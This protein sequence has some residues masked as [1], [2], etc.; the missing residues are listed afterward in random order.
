MRQGILRLETEDMARN[1]FLPFGDL[2]KAFR[3]RR[4][5]TQQELAALAGVHRNTIGRW[6]RGDI[7]PESRT[8]V[9]DLARVLCLDALET[10]QLLA[11]SLTTQAL[12]WDIPYPRNPLFTGR[13]KLLTRLHERMQSDLAYGLPPSYALQGLGGIGKTQTALEYAYRYCQDATVVLWIRGET[14]E[15]I[16]RSFVDIAELL[17][18]PER[19]LANQQQI[20]LAVQDWLVQTHDWLA[21]WDNVEEVDLLRRFL[22]ARRQGSVLL[23]TRRHALGN[24]AQGIELPPLPPEEGVLFLLRRAKLLEPG[25]GRAQLQHL[26]ER[27]P[28]EYAAAEEL[29]ALLDGLPL[30]LDQVG[31]YV[32][33]TG[34]GL[35]TYLRYFEPYQHQLLGRRGTPQ[36]DHPASVMRTF[37]MAYEQVKQ[38]HPAAAELLCFCTLLAPDAI[39]EELIIKGAPHLGPILQPVA[40]DPY[41]LDA[42]IA[43]LRSFSLI[44]RQAETRTLSL[45]RLVQAVL[46]E[47]LDPPPVLA[48]AERVVRAVNAAFP[49]FSPEHWSRYEAY[50]PHAQACRTLITQTDR[51]VPEAIELFQKAGRYLLSRG[52]Y[53]ETRLFLTQAHILQQRQPEPDQLE[54]AVTF[55]LLGE[56]YW[57][58]EAHEEAEALWERALLTREQLLGVMHPLTLESLN[59]VALAYWCQKRYSQAE[60][61]LVR[62][63]QLRE[64]LLGPSHPETGESLNNLGFAYLQQ[65]KYD[66]AEPLLIRAVDIHEQHI[67][68][69]HPCTATCLKNL[70]V[71]YREQGKYA[72]AE[73]ILKRVLLIC[74]RHMVPEHFLT[75]TCLKDLEVLYQ[76]QGRS[77]SIC[78]SPLS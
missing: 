74:E 65:R 71:L 24:L 51:Q 39:P 31:A 52:N 26:A 6:E 70:A 37:I 76:K 63:L 48:W 21:I 56:L 47:Q 45:H 58:Q 5:L 16:T 20:V 34:C 36:E 42:A 46:R 19:R 15:S 55:N 38:V 69:E 28:E 59:N 13:D 64:E 61:M 50:L 40:A 68:P 4:R 3:Q 53:S 14:A 78:I 73:A 44:Q 7:L 27:L 23:T 60:A 77:A 33:E 29:A 54:I 66:Q 2:C 32:E 8:T 41:Q 49:P 1:V 57:A 43:T 30:A 17:G 25:V 12:S 75:K 72:Q 9:L 11:A 35:T 67:G 10:R 18:L 62:T 22:P